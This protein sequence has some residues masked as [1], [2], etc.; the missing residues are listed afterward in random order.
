MDLL[1]QAI[2]Q[3]LREAA[4]R[5]EWD[6]EVSK[7][8][9]LVALQKEQ[10]ARPIEVRN[11]KVAVRRVLR[12]KLPGEWIASHTDIEARTQLEEMKAGIRK[13]CGSVRC[14]DRFETVRFS[15]GDVEVRAHITEKM[16]REALDGA[17]QQQAQ[18]DLMPGNAG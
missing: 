17:L 2:A 1:E 7:G 16:T 15:N 4:A 18:R 3:Q 13:W 9:D 10:L 11:E 8:R 5:D 14:C 6:A 12:V